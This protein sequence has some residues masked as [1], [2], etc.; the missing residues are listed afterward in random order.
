MWKPLLNTFYVLRL[1]GMFSI[2][3][4]ERKILPADFFLIYE[5]IHSCN[6]ILQHLAEQFIHA[7]RICLPFH[8]LHGLPY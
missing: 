6:L 8:C 3:G 4:F 1:I 7:C 5:R 2:I